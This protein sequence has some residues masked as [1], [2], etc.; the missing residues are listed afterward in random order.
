MKNSEPYV[1][2][3]LKSW[4]PDIQYEVPVGKAKPDFSIWEEESCKAFWE[5]ADRETSGEELASLENLGLRVDSGW[6]ESMTFI[7]LK[8]ARK[9]D[10]F[11]KCGN[12]PGML[13]LAEWVGIA[14]PTGSDISV[15]FEGWPQIE[16]TP[17][18]PGKFARNTKKAKMVGSEWAPVN[19]AISAVGILR[20]TN[21]EGYKWGLRDFAYRVWAKFDHCEHSA[22]LIAN[23]Q[24]RIQ[25]CGVD[26]EH[27]TAYLQIYRNLRAH[28]PWPLDLHG[29]FDQ[30]FDVTP[31]S[32]DPINVFDGL[33]PDARIE[34]PVSRVQAEIDALA[35][36]PNLRSTQ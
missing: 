16:I 23:A 17:G 3:Y 29:P 12:L 26:L 19:N 24:D 6:T 7:A 36:D 34:I 22:H 8:V 30:V 9:S 31:G 32:L 14:N 18:R 11:G 1:Y 2:D 4:R 21:V 27:K 5:V 10:Q 20:R 35:N 25:K 33:A 15:V 13:V 28:N